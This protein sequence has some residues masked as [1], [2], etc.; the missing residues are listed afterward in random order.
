MK[1]NG[2][3]EV[4]EMK[5]SRRMEKLKPYLFVEI[6]NKINDLSR[7]LEEAISIYRVE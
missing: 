6:V 2:R 4:L 1:A 7:Q 5:L 3:I